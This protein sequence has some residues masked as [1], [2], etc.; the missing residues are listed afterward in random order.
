MRKEN[1]YLRIYFVLLLLIT[2]RSVAFSQCSFQEFS[3]EQDIDKKSE[4]CIYLTNE[5]LRGDLD[6]L[7]IISVELLISAAEAKSAF[8]KAIGYKCLASYQIRTGEIETGL[9]H[10]LDAKEYFER[11]QD[12]QLLSEIYN[13]I[14]NAHYLLGEYNDAIKAYLKSLEYGKTSPDKTDAFNGKNGLGK[15]YCALGDTAVGVYTMAEYKNESIKA[16]KFEAA[17]DAYAYLGQIEMER[18]NILLAKE[19]YGK[20]VL[21]SRRSDSKVHLSHALN[22]QAILQFNL[23]DMDSS[24]YY[25]E[26][27]LRLREQLSN[28][29]GIVESYYNLGFFYAATSDFHNGYI[30][31]NRSAEIAH[32]NNFIGDELDAL[33]ELIAICEELGYKEEQENYE[34]RALVLSKHI[35]K[36]NTADKD[37]VAYAEGIIESVAVE[38][39]Q[40]ESEE[41]ESNS[42]IWILLG[43][44]ALILLAVVL[45]RRK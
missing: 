39:K 2:A 23:G 32:D 8:G 43:G 41:E 36:K 12:P 17:A 7:K 28:Y 44:V 6:S 13:E 22:N 1:H 18:G 10:F 31:Y 37:I 15:S 38:D 11:K 40:I 42:F 33:N 21:F 19:Y 25:F 14:G 20:S 30:N 4:M 16:S 26:E 29:K 3:N 35:E 9:E 27:S 34:A 45:K 5:Y 24:L